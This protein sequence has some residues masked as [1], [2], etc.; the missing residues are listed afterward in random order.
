M[1]KSNVLAFFGESKPLR[2][3]TEADA[4]DFRRFLLEGKHREQGKTFKLSENTVRRRCAVA[5]QFFNRAVKQRLL[6]VNPFRELKGEVMGN[7]EKQHF[8]STADADS[9][10]AACPDA[11]WRLLFA[12]ARYGGLRC[13]SEHLA[14]KWAGVDWEKGRLTVYSPNTTAL[15]PLKIPLRSGR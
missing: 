12:L 8:I 7:E 1:V 11:E 15:I 14:L 10:L 13:P 9:V 4:E 5:K 2:E 6:A 3:I